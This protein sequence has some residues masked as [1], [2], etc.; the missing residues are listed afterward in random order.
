MNA[1]I[2]KPNDD[3]DVLYRRIDQIRM[4]E[5]ERLVAKARLAR[6]EAVAGMLVAASNAVRR[7]VRSLA[8]RTGHRPAHSAR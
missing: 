3:L 4:S 6:A 7:L 8:G 2:S 1:K 5:Q